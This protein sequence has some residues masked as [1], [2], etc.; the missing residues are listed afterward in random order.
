MSQSP[1]RIGTAGWNVPARYAA[2]LPRDGSQLERYA[3]ALNAVEI[4]SS[5]YRPHHRATYERW[6]QST[7]AGF[8]FSVKMPRTITR[9]ARLNNCSAM[10]DRFVA[11]V[12]GLHE[13]LG[14]LLC[15]L[16]RDSLSTKRH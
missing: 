6:A 8:R 15:S 2:E 13:E 1:L 7:P 12:M 16:R 4:N 14:V 10:L 11:E 9:F 5:F 3:Q